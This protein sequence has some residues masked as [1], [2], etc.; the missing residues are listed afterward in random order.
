MRVFSEV[1]NILW[2]GREALE[3]QMWPLGRKLMITDLKLEFFFFFFYLH[4]NLKSE[5]SETRC[6]LLWWLWSSASHHGNFLSTCKCI[7]LITLVLLIRCFSFVLNARVCRFASLSVSVQLRHRAKH[8]YTLT[9]TL[10]MD[11]TGC[12]KNRKSMKFKRERNFPQQYSKCVLC[13][14][15]HKRYLPWYCIIL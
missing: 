10:Q 14:L 4:F 15:S 2:A 3:G 5:H 8:R 9:K 13:N 11:W 12:F 6:L 7:D 1:I